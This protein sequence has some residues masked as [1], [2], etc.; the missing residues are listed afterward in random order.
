VGSILATKW[1]TLPH[2]ITNLPYRDDSSTDR[3]PNHTTGPIEKTAGDE[4]NATCWRPEDFANP[5]FHQTP[6][7]VPGLGTIP[8]SSIYGNSYIVREIF[9]DQTH[10]FIYN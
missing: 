2:E 5:L 4:H 6:N 8:N 9:H 1:A 7:I 10:M 3:K